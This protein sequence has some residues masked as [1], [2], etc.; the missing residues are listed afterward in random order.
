MVKTLSKNVRN[1]SHLTRL[2]VF[3]PFGKGSQYIKDPHITINV[4]WWI[5]MLD[6]LYSEAQLLTNQ[7]KTYNI[8]LF[9]KLLLWTP[10]EINTLCP[11]RYST[12]WLGGITFKIPWNHPL[13]HYIQLLPAAKLT[14]HCNWCF[15]KNSITL[16]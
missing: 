4:I 3:S 8:C 9:Q 12:R 11:L 14:Y 15:A 16:Y 13:P 6:Y 5:P 1:L 2:R 10:F 7:V